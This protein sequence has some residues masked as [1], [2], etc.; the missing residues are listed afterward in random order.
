MTAM[1]VL[2]A[3]LFG[4]VTVTANSVVAAAIFHGTFN[5]AAALATYGVQGGR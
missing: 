4:Y 3:P 2:L 5:G 1:T